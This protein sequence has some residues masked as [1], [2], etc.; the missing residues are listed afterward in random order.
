[1]KHILLAED[2]AINQL[3]AIKTIK[4]L[5]YTVHAVENG[6]ELLS[7]LEKEHFDLILMDCQ[8]PEMD[9]F[10]AT[11]K[12]RTSSQAWNKIPIIA[13]TSSD[14]AVMQEGKCL[15]AGMN[16]YLTK[17]VDPEILATTLTKWLSGS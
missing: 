17:P 2:N 5:G 1:M 4:K 14:L 13:L 12:I 3:V 9:G 16:G 10:E 11:R 15:E 7:A 8:M 6:L